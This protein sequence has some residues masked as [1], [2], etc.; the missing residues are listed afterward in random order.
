MMLSPK[1]ET[2][3]KLS[4]YLKKSKAKFLI[5]PSLLLLKESSI[6]CYKINFLLIKRFEIAWL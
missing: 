6:E 5:L 2:P 1:W 4:I 3:K